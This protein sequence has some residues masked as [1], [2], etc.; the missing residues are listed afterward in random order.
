MKTVRKDLKIMSKRVVITGLAPITSI[1]IGKDEFFNNLINLKTNIQKLPDSFNKKYKFKTGFYVPEPDVKL[2]DFEISSVFNTI[3]GNASKISI[4]ATKLALMDAGFE[5]NKKDKLFYLDSKYDFAIILG[6]GIGNLDI[7]FKSHVAHS[8]ENRDDIF[9]IIGKKL[10]Y[11]RM[12]IP[13]T[14]PNSTSA[15]LSILF[16]INGMNYTLNASCASGTYAIGDAFEKIQDGKHKIVITGGV[17]CL[18]DYSGSIMRGFDTLGALTKSEDGIPMPFSK[19]RSGFLFNEG[20]CCIIILEELD[21]ALERGAEIY[22]EIIDYESNSDAYS[23]VQ[24]EES[25]HNIIKLIKKLIKNKKIDYINAH[26]TG[27]TTND[28]IEAKV[29]QEIFGDKNNQPYINSTKGI[30]GHSIGASGALEAAVTALSIKKG[31]IHNNLIEDPIDNLNVN[32]DTAKIDIEYAIS[33]SYGF[34]GHNGAIL[35]KRYEK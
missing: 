33:T 1:G 21:H 26:G 8:F 23:I 32:T 22:A 31:I 28:E 29:I 35:F 9:D 6:V 30:I 16:G 10:R 12:V 11:N 5:I 19:K 7:S 4:A 2:E 27:T 25:G 14:M 20:A 17:E 24:I 13:L 15:W 3:V 34:G 18:N